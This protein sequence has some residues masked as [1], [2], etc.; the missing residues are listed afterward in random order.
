M[1]LRDLDHALYTYTV[2]GVSV[3]TNIETTE[4]STT[5]YTD[6]S[7]TVIFDPYTPTRDAELSDKQTENSDFLNIGAISGCDSYISR[8]GNVVHITRCASTSDYAA[9]I[10]QV[11]P[12]S[13]YIQKKAVLHASAVVVA[14]NAVAFVGESG[15]GKSTLGEGLNDLG[16]PTLSDDL[17]PCRIKSGKPCVPRLQPNTDAPMFLPLQSV[18]FLE[19][20]NNIDEALTSAL[21]KP[22]F[23][24]NLIHNGFGDLAHKTIWDVEFS[25][26][27][28]LAKQCSGYSLLIPDNIEKS[29]S[30][31]KSVARL[32]NEL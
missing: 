15:A 8:D 4:L 13:S 19:R 30:S 7:V 28:L 2:S 10:R 24:Q 31:I 9:I 12:Y 5:E 16:F 17:L 20:R 6:I 3:Q 23:F 22:V 14:D 27:E 18:Y 1:N 29:T 25:F 32:L 11:V 21:S 26:Y